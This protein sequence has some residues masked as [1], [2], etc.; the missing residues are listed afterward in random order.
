MSTDVK[1]TS[2][3]RP[4][5]LSFRPAVRASAIPPSER[6]TSRQPVNRFFLFHSLSPWRT[7]TRRWSVVFLHSPAVEPSPLRCEREPSLEEPAPDLIRE[8]G[9]DLADHPSRAAT[10]PPQ[11]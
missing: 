9:P 8:R 4:W 10:R 2:N 5:A 11:D 7:S 6:S 3:L 1:A